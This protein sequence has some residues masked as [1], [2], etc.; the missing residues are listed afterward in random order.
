MTTFRVFEND[1][2]YIVADASV[3][4]RSFAVVPRNEVYDFNTAAE[5]AQQA[6]RLNAMSNVPTRGIETPERF[7]AV[8]DTLYGPAW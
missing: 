6:K 2:G 7:E 1:G 3:R 8:A 5:A 4:A